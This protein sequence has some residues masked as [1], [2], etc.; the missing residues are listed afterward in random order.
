ML[1]KLYLEIYIDLYDLIKMPEF[2]YTPN[3]IRPTGMYISRSK[4]L[5]I[6]NVSFEKCPLFASWILNS[7]HIMFNGINIRNSKYQWNGDGLHFSSCHD[8]EVKNCNILASDDCVAVDSDYGYKS[9]NYNIH[10][11]VFESTIHI[12]RIYTGLDF[13]IYKSCENDFEKLKVSNSIDCN[14]RRNDF[15]DFM[16]RFKPYTCTG[17]HIWSFLRLIWYPC[18]DC[19]YLLHHRCRQ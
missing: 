3:K 2:S 17:G 19:L 1:D 9:Y 12:V 10:D 13:G 15:G 5:K 7:S 18:F 4:N 11:C 8:V 16:W 6:E 14:Y